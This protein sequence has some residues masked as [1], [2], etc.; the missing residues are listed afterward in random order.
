MLAGETLP[1]GAP[2]DAVQ[3]R[4]P[5]RFVFLAEYRRPEAE[6]GRGDD[7]GR[8]SASCGIP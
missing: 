5:E 3:G 1:V 6:G 7:P 4:L 2:A 8:V